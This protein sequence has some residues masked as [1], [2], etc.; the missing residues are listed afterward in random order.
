MRARLNFTT[1]QKTAMEVRKESII[2]LGKGSRRAKVI[3]HLI[4]ME[5]G[6]VLPFVPRKR[7]SSDP[8]DLSM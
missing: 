6:L 4:Y 3:T 2:F 7:R 1:T 5:E 8:A